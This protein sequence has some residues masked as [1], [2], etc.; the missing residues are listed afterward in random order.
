MIY[1]NIGLSFHETV[2]L[3][4]YVGF[5]QRKVI[6]G[7]GIPNHSK[8]FAIEYK[9]QNVAPPILHDSCRPPPKTETKIINKNQKGNQN[10]S[11]PNSA[12]NTPNVK[13][14]GNFKRKSRFIEPWPEGKGYLSKSGNS[15][16][17]EFEQYFRGFCY[18]CG[19]SSHSGEKCRT[20]PEK[21]AVISLCSVCRQGFH[22]TCKS[23]RPD[24]KTKFLN[25]QIE[26][27]SEIYSAIQLSKKPTSNKIVTIGTGSGVTGFTSDEDSE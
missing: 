24:L 17:K 16:S 19:N 1:S 11:R 14:K 18:K 4:P 23:R 10:S 2:P 8:V 6:R 20:Y 21:T 27:L 12:G 25:K 22:E 5:K 26:Q 7:S 15:L 9:P 3:N 13:R